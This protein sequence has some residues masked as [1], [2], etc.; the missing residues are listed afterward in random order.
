MHVSCS[1]NI[2]NIVENFAHTR[3]V[4]LFV[5]TPC[6]KPWLT[7][8]TTTA[9]E[10]I[11]PANVR[12]PPKMTVIFGADCFLR[13]SRTLS[14]I[15]Y[16]PGREWIELKALSCSLIAA[17]QFKWHDKLLWNQENRRQHSECRRLNGM[18]RKL[19][20]KLHSQNNKCQKN[21]RTTCTACSTNAPPFCVC[22]ARRGPGTRRKATRPGNFGVKN[23][24]CHADNIKNVY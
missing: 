10:H 11:E 21:I 8:A 9:T 15:L 1:D 3:F 19:R 23:Y 4:D 5:W 7:T 17:Q 24:F 20:P 6:R 12:F 22:A 13:N 2:I 18:Q 16:F 14:R